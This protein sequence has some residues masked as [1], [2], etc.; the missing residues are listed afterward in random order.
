MRNQAYAAPLAKR[1]PVASTGM[2]AAVRVVL[3]LVNFAENL[4]RQLRPRSVWLLMIV[5]AAIYYP[6]FV[7]LPGGMETYPQAASCLWHG[8]MLQACDAGF[9]YPPFFALVMLPF[10]PMPLWLR[11]LAWYV[12]TLAA[13]IG[14][15]KLSESIAR[16]ALPAPLGHA[17]LCWLRFFA[18]L[19][20]AKLILAVFE[21]QAYDALVVVA[22][23]FGLAALCEGRAFVA[24]ASLAF[25]AALKA[26]PLIFLPYLLWKRHF[27]AAAIFGVVYALA[28]LLPDILF[29]PADGDAYFSAYFSTY[30]STWLHQVAGPAFGINPAGAPF[31]F[32]DGANIL[33]HSLRG[34]ISLN[35]DEAHSR[36]VFDTALAAAD[37]SLIIVVGTLIALLPRRSRSV[38]IDGSLLLI[39][40]LMLSPMTS[41]PHYVALL[42]P[43]MTLVALNLRDARSAALGRT[44]LAVS[45]AL[46]T[47]AGNDAVGE[48]F[49]VWA[50]RRSAMVLGTLVL[51]I[52]FAALVLQRQ[53]SL[54]G[55]LAA[56]PLVPA[57]TGTQ[58]AS[59][60]PF[61]SQ[62]GFPPSRE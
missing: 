2:I 17:E 47:L 18:L 38:A 52:Y 16:K 23:L 3:S 54:I 43:Y 40:M 56:R 33:N 57:T 39:A 31:A 5:A 26:T 51:L 4:G 9:T 36:S 24:G 28:S 58:R 6:R 1:Y 8:Q 11:D 60:P 32:W 14:S 22:A 21:N 34:A 45:F 61:R 42:L 49:T 7:K 46:V 19:L 25:A 53:V 41:R 37:G 27:T 29:G 35:I 62:S 44:V 50:Y 59:E 48:A 15:F 10:A 55:N 30:F 20:S 13:T 12:V